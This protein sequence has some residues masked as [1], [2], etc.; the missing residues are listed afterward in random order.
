MA[1]T[2]LMSD[3]DILA[4]EAEAA[5]AAEAE[6]KAAEE[7]EAATA[8]EA[9]TAVKEDKETDSVLAAEVAALR[10]VLES[11]VS[12]P[13]STT[14]EVEIE[15]ELDFLVNP[16]EAVRKEVAKVLKAE[17][18]A[19][20]QYNQKASKAQA[21]LSKVHPDADAVLRSAEFVKFR[22]ENP[23]LDKALSQARE[24]FDVAGR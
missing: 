17:R 7:A 22:Q 2:I 18:D 3:E 19:D 5:K 15:D 9:T 4:L 21:E 13:A 1:A 23:L 24:S 11:R 20:S 14:T 10:A 6:A 16:A 8:A 12:P